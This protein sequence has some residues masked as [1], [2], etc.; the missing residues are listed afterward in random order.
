M[1]VHLYANL[2]AVSGSKDVSIKLDSVTVQGVGVDS[3][4]YQNATTGSLELPLNPNSDRTQFVVTVQQS[5]ITYTDTLTFLHSNEPWFE[6]PECG[7]RVNST[8][9]GCRVTGTIF[10]GYRI[11]DSLVTN[12]ATEHVRLYL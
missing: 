6:S 11:Q 10:G 5:G 3:L 7:C 4:L 12:Y 1:K 2:Y 8:L 9:K